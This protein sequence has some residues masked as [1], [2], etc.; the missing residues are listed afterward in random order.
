LGPL[1]FTLYLDRVGDILE[2]HDIKH[3]LYADDIQL[4]ISYKPTLDNSDLLLK[5]EKIE[6]C[7]DEIKIWMNANYLHLNEEKTEFMYIGKKQN[8]E[9]IPETMELRIGKTPRAS[10]TAKSIGCVLDKT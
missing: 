3:H 1:L 9:L 6:H 2:K 5:K 8:L 7:L 4:Y 10:D